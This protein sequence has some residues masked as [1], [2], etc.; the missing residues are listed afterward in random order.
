MSPTGEERPYKDGMRKDADGFMDIVWCRSTVLNSWSDFRQAFQTANARKAFAPTQFNP[1]SQRGHC[2]MVI[3]VTFPDENNPGMKKRGRIYVGDLSGTEPAGDLFYAKYEKVTEADGSTELKLV[4]PHK[5][6]SK[7]KKLQDQGK[8]INLSLSELAQF[9]MKMA[10]A[11]KKKK[12]KPGQSIPGCNAYFLCKYLKDTIVQARTYL[13]CAIRPEVTYIPYTFATLGFAKNASTIKVAP[14]Q[15]NV[16]KSAAERKLEAELAEMK[17]LYELQAQQR[18]V[19]L[20][21][22]EDRLAG[23]INDDVLRSYHARATSK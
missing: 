13:F 22:E 21:K 4:G 9:F 8:K 14:K 11:V 5:D 10:D 17:K 15:A 19:P 18:T 23:E 6:Q 2:I 12:L 1:Q 16:H 3:D 20:E 7:T